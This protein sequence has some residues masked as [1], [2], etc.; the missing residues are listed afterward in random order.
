MLVDQY[1]VMPPVG[2]EAFAVERRRVLAAEE[3][4]VGV[5]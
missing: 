4:A 5:R 2:F 1:P 3:N